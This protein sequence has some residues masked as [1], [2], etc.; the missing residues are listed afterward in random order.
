MDLSRLEV[1]IH[2]SN[3]ALDGW[4]TVSFQN[5]TLTPEDGVSTSIQRQ[6]HTPH[7]V[8]LNVGDQFALAWRQ[9]G[10][11]VLI[12]LSGLSKYGTPVTAVFDI[13]LIKGPMPTKVGPLTDDELE[14]LVAIAREKTLSFQDL[15]SSRGYTSVLDRRKLKHS[16]ERLQKAGLIDIGNYHSDDGWNLSVTKPGVEYLVQSGLA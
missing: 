4:L 15:L 3:Q 16:L 12:K 7:R 13:H 6:G 1:P 2:Q 9:P 11:H 5:L 14:M 8:I 10:S